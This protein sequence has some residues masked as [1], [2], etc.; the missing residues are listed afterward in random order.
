MGEKRSGWFSNSCKISSFVK[1]YWV[2]NTTYFD[3]EISKSNTVSDEC[4]KADSGNTNTNEF[5]RIRITNS[6]FLI[7]Y[8]N[9]VEFYFKK[10][11]VLIRTRYYSAYDQGKF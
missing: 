1:V 6:S 11:F 8:I 2:F 3:I 10:L 7:S 5:Y 9:D 4:D